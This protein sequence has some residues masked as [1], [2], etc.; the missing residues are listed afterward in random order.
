LELIWW[1][2][3]AVLIGLVL[4]PI[5]S[6]G[7]TYPFWKE[8]TCFII[9][10]ITSTRYV[11]LLKYTPIAVVQWSKVAVLLFSVPCLYLLVSWFHA[12]Q[13]YLDEGGV[14]SLVPAGLDDGMEGALTGYI[15]TQMLFFA[16]GALLSTIVLPFRMLVSFW[17][18]HNRGT[19]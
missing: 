3:S 19:V 16:T 13:L 11:F 9:A 1:V 10:F 15:R 18:T 4:Y 2:F 6:S 8:N 12:F 17:R 14:L 7:I 5:F